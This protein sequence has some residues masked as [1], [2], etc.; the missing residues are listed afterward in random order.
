[1]SKQNIRNRIFQVHKT[2]PN[3]V[4][5]QFLDINYEN[6]ETLKNRRWKENSQKKELFTY[7]VQ[8]RD[9]SQ[10]F[11]VYSKWRKNGPQNYGGKYLP[12]NLFL[13]FSE[14]P[15]CDI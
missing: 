10:N 13:N 7:N 14:Y 5:L 2:W 12:C 8:A 3:M 1:M 6:L 15:V 11:R 9:T 4:Q